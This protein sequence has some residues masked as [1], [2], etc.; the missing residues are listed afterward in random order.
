MRAY[1]WIKNFGFGLVGVL[2]MSMTVLQ[3]GTVIRGT[4]TTEEG[5][6]LPYA[7]IY[8]EGGLDG[9]ISDQA[10]VFEFTT[11]QSGPAVVVCQ[12]MGYRKWTQSI[13]LAA[14]VYRLAI[15]MRASV[16]SR[17]TIWVEAGSYR[18]A[19]EEHVTLS[20]LDVVRT[21]GAAADLF[22]AIK[23]FPGLQQVDEGAGLFVRG[24]DVTE[25]IITLDDAVIRHPYKFESPTGGFFGCFSPFLL[26]GTFFSSGGYSAL[27]G[28]ALSS[29][30]AMESR[31]IPHQPSLN[32]GLGLAAESGAL[33][34]PLIN[35][36]LGLNFS[37]N[38]SNTEMLFRLN[39]TRDDFIHYPSS[40][41]LNL[42]LIWQIT[43]SRQ[44]KLFVYQS[45]DK[46]GASVD[47]PDYATF[48]QG[49]GESRFYNLRYRDG[50]RHRQ[51][52]SNLAW[53]DYRNRM[54]M[55][56]LDLDFHDRQLQYRLTREG[57]FSSGLVWRTGGELF[58]NLTDVR[59]TVPQDE[60]NFDPLAPVKR[61]DTD[62]RSW[63]PAGFSEWEW[64]RA[65]IKSTAGIRLSRESQSGQWMLDPRV[66]LVRSIRSI[67]NLSLA[68]GIFH[69]IPDAEYY[70]DWVGN[71]DLDPMRAMHYI[72]GISR[73]SDESIVRVEGYYK[74][75]THLIQE[76][77]LLNYIND[78]HGYAWGMDV[79]IKHSWGPF[80]GRFSY[81]F[82]K[83]RRYWLDAPRISSPE[84][85]IPHNLNLVLNLNL[86][87][88]FG[89]G[90]RMQYASGK[91]YTSG[92]DR[93]HDCRVPPFFKCDLTLTWMGEL[94][95]STRTTFYLAV[96]NLTDRENIFDYYYSQ[97]FLRRS[98]R[99]S[100]FDR[101][102]YFGLVWDWSY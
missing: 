87:A 35:E 14:P 56:A 77:S 3:A 46:V 97:D 95:A 82:L 4:V 94:I 86:P 74:R 39:H 27:W 9:T 42:N 69:Q 10:G 52:K 55:A 18:A 11:E 1:R 67:W 96:S 32:F 90:G 44:L 64:I 48:Y 19:D 23:S 16:L 68:W 7:N 6:V 2:I 59:G 31:E 36:K 38:H 50:D 20:S 57:Y 43:S 66:S 79:F 5:E 91:P 60:D 63:N 37:G 26:K 61:F 47:N 84:F 72:V 81:S 80:S 12:F 98:A 100:S 17:D 58:Y 22:W 73:Q 78:G 40:Y 76:D 28:N 41:D 102:I 85:D 70:D 65:G 30:L 33:S 21:P 83:A 54:D 92:P 89:L 93:Y 45:Q 71:S 53:S 62:Y 99:C 34:L 101:S 51:I 49:D 29:A 75:Y 25:N 24:G 88:G 8:L 15:V 13:D